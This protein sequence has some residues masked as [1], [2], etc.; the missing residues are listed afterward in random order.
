MPWRMCKPMDEKIRFVARLLDGEKMAPLCR[1]FEISRVT[2][3]K[4][5]ERYKELGL[6][7]LND[8][9]RRPYRHANRLPYQI[10]RTILRLKREYPSWGARKI[11]DKLLQDFPM[12]K[13]PAK[14]TIHAVLDRHGL[15]KKRKRRRHSK[16]EGTALSHA[17]ENNALWCADYKGEFRMGNNKYCY[18]LTVTDFSSRY[19][20]ACEALES[21]KAPP[22]FA[23]FERVF[24]EFGIPRAIRTD[25]GVPFAAPNAFFNL[26]ALSVWWLRLGINIERIKPGNPQQ[27]GRH[28]RMHLTLKDETTKPAE[29]NL[30]QQQ[31]RFDQFV[32]VYNTERPHPGERCQSDFTDMGSLY[33][34]IAGEPF[35]HL[36]YHF[37]L[38]YSNWEWIN[39]AYSES[40]EAL[41][42]GLQ[43]SLWEL[44]AVPLQH[45]TDNL[46]AATHD[47]RHS[48]G[49]DFNERYLAVVNHYRLQATRNNP[50]R[51]NENGDVESQNFHF[52][53]ALDQRLRLRGSRDFLTVADYMSFA[54]SVTRDRNQQRKSL[55]EEEL[56]VMRPLPARPLPACRE[57]VVTVSKWS[58]VRVAKKPYSVPSRLIGERLRVRLFAATVEMYYHDELIGAFDRLRGDEPYRIDYGHLVH[59]LLRKP[60]AF[61][62]YVY[63]EAL[64]PTLNFRR[65]YDALCEKRVGADLEYIRILHLAATT[66]EADVDAA[67]SGLL[68]TGQTPTFDVVREAVAPRE[69]DC[70]D[71]QVDAPDLSEYDQ[72]F[73]HEEVAA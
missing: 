73:D 8:R 47:L 23:V 61:A 18:P 43:A 45:R 1:E 57:E 37:V 9:C 7:G 39:L 15:V 65:A 50:G 59:S 24:R 40:F 38:T 11:R 4:I 72:L 12:F 64:Y 22:A 69:A 56:A 67:L 51:A 36:M 66:V 26:S 71:V 60:G 41:I 19:L 46:S 52:K 28:E 34:T 30:L 6:E 21:T 5:F 20:L 58:T 63:Q 70:P 53:R 31:E 49:R 14:S 16:P 29:Y 3:Y 48:R 68:D 54:I 27:N 55:L 35:P 32:G 44:G 10:E 25:N 33:V 42:D 62:R 17:R 2:G 13:P